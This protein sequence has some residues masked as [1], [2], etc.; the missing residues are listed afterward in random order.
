MKA[1]VKWIEGAQFMGETDNGHA[2]I[3]EASA[4]KT[5]TG[6]SPLEMLLMGMEAGASSDVVSI[7]QNMHQDIDDVTLEI[8]AERADSI[9]RVF[10]RSNLFSLSLVGGSRS[11]KLKWPFSCRLK[12]I[13]LLPKC[14][15]SPPRLSL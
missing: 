2:I 13:A 10:K 6:P 4:S 12:N 7:L 1:R 11:L 5:S 9:P 8:E 14:S 15:K 3:M